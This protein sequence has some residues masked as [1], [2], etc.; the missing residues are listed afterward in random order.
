MEAVFR[1]GNFFGFFQCLP[2]KFLFFPVANGWNST[3]FRPE[4]LLPFSIISGD[5][6]PETVIFSKLSGRFLSFPEDGITVLGSLSI[7]ATLDF[8][9]QHDVIVTV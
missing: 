5:F 6:L 1:A 9:D 2:A 8:M 3:I 4:V 7:I